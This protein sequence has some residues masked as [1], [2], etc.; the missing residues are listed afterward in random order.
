MNR[1]FPGVIWGSLKVKK[2]TR[3]FSVVFLTFRRR[4]FRTR[5]F[6]VVSGKRASQATNFHRLPPASTYLE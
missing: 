1:L 4:I 2:K 3:L 5:Y 6:T